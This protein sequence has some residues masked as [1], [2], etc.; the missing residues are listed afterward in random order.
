MIVEYIRY[1]IGEDRRSAFE[2][3]YATAAASL[4]TSP[5]CLGYELSHGHEEPDHYILRIEWDSLEGHERGFRSSPEFGPFFKAI[6]PY[7][8]DIREMRHYRITDVKSS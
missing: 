6:G 2:Q 3:A 5:N 4:D 1:A 7:V 8:S